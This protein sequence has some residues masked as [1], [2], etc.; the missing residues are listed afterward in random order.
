MPEYKIHYEISSYYKEPV[1]NAFIQILALPFPS[2]I[3]QV[4]NINIK[5]NLIDSEFRTKNMFGFQM[6]QYTS[7]QNIDHFFFSLHAV[8][9]VLHQNPFSFIPWPGQEEWDMLKTNDFYIDNVM[10]LRST[11]LTQ[12]CKADLENIF[13]IQRNNDVFTWLTE[14]NKFIYAYIKYTPDVT[15]TQ[16][17]AKEVI[18][19][20]MGV[21][22][23][24]AHLFIGI[25]R[26]F[27]IP[28][29]YVSG[30]LNQENNIEG[31]GQTHAWAEALLPFNGWIGFDPTNNLLIDHHY[32][33]IAHGIDYNDC[34]PISG[35]IE[36]AGDQTNTHIVKVIN[37]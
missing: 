19:L 34:S 29:R 28:C 26:L 12:L 17:T 11:P 23:D 21:C 37:Q 2:Q 3:Q 22:Q 32:I 15:N 24:F 1:K 13:S 14:L 33:K 25:A 9:S 10:F 18:K 8:V 4:L 20:K 30:Y 31:S 27:G 7:H 6:L 5:S 35:V 36:T 16:T